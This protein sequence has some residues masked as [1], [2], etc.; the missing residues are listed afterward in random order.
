MV[1][2]FD[3]GT[4]CNYPEASKD[5]FPKLTNFTIVT[6]PD[7]DPKFRIAFQYGGLGN[8]SLT[9]ID[10]SQLYTATDIGATTFTVYAGPTCLG[11][12]DFTQTID[13]QNLKISL[14][15]NPSGTK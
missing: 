7:A 1:Q 6:P 9:D 10:L 11:D 12:D 3:F 13:V 8:S 14:K 2:G 15:D 4:W 5:S